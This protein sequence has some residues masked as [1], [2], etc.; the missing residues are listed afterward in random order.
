MPQLSDRLDNLATAPTSSIL[1]SLRLL[2]RKT[3][4]VFTALKASVYSIVLQN[5]MATGGEGLGS[6]GHT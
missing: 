4:V 6:E 1:Q 3:P 2:E 5:S